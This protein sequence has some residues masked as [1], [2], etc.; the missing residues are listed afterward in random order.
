MTQAL[1]IHAGEELEI[2]AGN[3]RR[4]SAAYRLRL[5]RRARALGAEPL[6]DGATIAIEAEEKSLL[7]EDKRRIVPY[8]YPGLRSFEPGEGEIFFGRDRNVEAVR[9]LLAKNRVVAVLGGSGSGKSS[10]LRAGLLPFLNTKRRIPGRIG[11]WYNAEFRP[12]TEPLHE[13]ASA[14]AEQLILP[15]LAMNISGLAPEIGL[16]SDISTNVGAA[17]P[18]MRERFHARLVEASKQGREAVLKTFTDIAERLL[19]RADD[20]VT[21]GLRLAEPSLFLLVDQLEEVFRPEVSHEERDALVNLIVDLHAFAADRKGRVY[22]ALT[23]RSEELHRCA[24]HRGLS[25]VVF[26]SGYQLEILDPGDPEDRAD[27]RLAIIQPG[28][29]AF[30]DWGLRDWIERKDED[31]DRS[32]Q[33]RDA[34]FSPGMPDLLLAAAARLSKELEHRPDQL[35]LLQH[36]LQAIWHSA[37][38]RWSHGVAHLEQLE[39]TPEDLPGYHGGIQVPDLGECLNLRADDACVEAAGRFAASAGTTKATGEQA[40]TAAFRSLARRD[41]IG[42]WARRFAGRDDIEVFLQAESNSE[43]ARIP[44][45]ARW[46]ALQKALNAFLLRGDLNGGGI[47]DY[48]ISHE[49]LIRNWRKFQLWLRDPREVAYSLAR[50]LREVEEPDKFVHLSDQEKID[51]I[52][53]AL[54]VRVAMVAAEGQL[55]TSWG[56]DQI[57]PVLQNLPTRARWGKSKSE[58]LDKVIALAAMADQARQ[59]VSQ[60]EF[61][62]QFE[63]EREKKKAKIK[64]VMA[65]L[66]AGSIALAAGCYLVLSTK[67]TREAQLEAQK[68]AE[69][70]RLTALARDAL[71]S[72]GPATAILVAS[73]VKDLGLEEAPEAEHLLLTSLH[74][75]REER[76]LGGG[77]KQ[78]VNGVSYS[79]DGEVLVT[80][81]PGTVL[82]WNWR[83][84]LLIDRIE[85]SYLPFSDQKFGGPI[86]GAQWS[87]G[88]NWIAIYSREQAMLFA[89]CS[90]SEFR[91]KFVTCAGKNEDIVQVLGDGKD[92]VGVAK[93]SAYG[94]WMVTGGFGA[95]VK[96]WDV[97][98]PPIRKLREFP[99]GAISW[100]NAFAIS[101]DRKSVAAGLGQ[102]EVQVFDSSSGALLTTL[103]I[104]E[105]VHGNFVAIA[106]NPQNSRMLAASLADGNIFVWDD[107]RDP[108]KA[109]SPIQ[110]RHAR[111]VAFQIAFSGDG[112]YL[113]GSSDDGVVRMWETKG[114]KATS[115][116]DEI[117]QLR[118]HKGP[119]W[120]V[121]V[122]P[123]GDHIASGSTDGS[124]ISWNR[125]SAFEPHEV[126][127]APDTANAPAKRS[128]NS[129]IEDPK[130]PHDL[131]AP[132]A[133]IRSPHGRTLVALGDG[134]LEVFDADPNV[135]RA[136]GTYRIGEQVV[137]LT[138]EDN[139]LIVRTRSGSQTEWP[140][141]DSIGDLVTYSLSRLPFVGSAT[142]NRRRRSVVTSAT[143]GMAAKPSLNST[144]DGCEKWLRGGRCWLG[145]MDG[146]A[147]RR[148]WARRLPDNSKG[149]IGNS[150][151]L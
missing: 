137:G 149:E 48:D 135:S 35:P 51:L 55:P 60:Q 27:L 126:G 111:G 106:F 120:A 129:C 109:A 62:K 139:R 132:V 80:S 69:M 150:L 4:M 6:W 133:C 94:R 141:F 44:A 64:V 99:G 14:L 65:V 140:F 7:T 134:Q 119:V 97:A 142:V 83:S 72:D 75:L 136:V 74:Q 145:N 63:E 36:A 89:P 52:P 121:A 116:W 82:F 9:N 101:S 108:E 73:R 2:F 130:L 117:G 25:D 43:L 32:K 131:A 31:A 87:P 144:F 95:P 122:S 81:D 128:S 34:P 53:Q 127:K 84:G 46:T 110:L 56:E 3:M 147:V 8:P 19:D 20:V 67:W 88:R 103:N 104:G 21:G 54:A 138:L 49:A 22:L 86:F 151:V 59:N 115:Q 40:L 113:V 29:N 17:A 26:G 79:P 38:K 107:W 13:L 23:M 16:P 118:G 37:M 123:H 146:S 148:Q 77:H 30:A 45:E 42:N 33:G 112:D 39:I 78:M 114:D 10:L 92:R 124:I 85:L 143:N 70:R 28:R 61:R 76:L 11:N 15:L 47:R 58:A 71:W 125:H 57:A 5:A 12:R 41:D 66:A 105:V 90:R 100:P 18:W 24:E 1:Q 98:A 93:F 102:G 50:I 91:D 96:L 68:V